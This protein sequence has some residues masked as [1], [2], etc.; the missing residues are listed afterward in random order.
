[1]TLAVAQGA[2]SLAAYPC[3]RVNG[4]MTLNT[5]AWAALPAWGVLPALSEFWVT[6]AARYARGDRQ[7]QVRL[8]WDDDKLFIGLCLFEPT[9]TDIG[10]PNLAG[11]SVELFFMQKRPTYYR[12]AVDATGKITLARYTHNMFQVVEL[13]TESCKAAVVHGEGR[14][15]LVVQIPFAIFGGTPADGYCWRANIARVSALARDD[16]EWLTSWA[17]LP[18]RNYHEY[19][20]YRPIVFHRQELT[21]ERATAIADTLNR[22]HEQYIQRYR[23]LTRERIRLLDAITASKAENISILANTGVIPWTWGTWDLISKKPSS[24][25]DGLGNGWHANE[26]NLPQ[27]ATLVWGHPVTFNTVVLRWDGPQSFPQRYSLEW[28]DGTQ[29]HLLNETRE[30]DAPLSIHTVPPVT[31]TR[32]RLTIYAFAGLGYYDILARRIETYNL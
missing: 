20:F 17:E 22:T 19:D 9:V 1:M 12:V 25:S 16:S 8:G 18:H 4:K 32:L 30:N 11:E 29:Y 14:W 21:S 5:P 15:S 2:S 10:I 26:S 13:P 31:T 24:P 6:P 28:W 23:E 7:S 27:M 3:Y